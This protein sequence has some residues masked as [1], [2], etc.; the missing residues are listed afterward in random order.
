[1]EAM[2]NVELGEMFTTCSQPG[3][4][5]RRGGDS[6]LCE[7]C[8]R[9][10]GEQMC[11]DGPRPFAVQPRVELGV[12]VHHYPA[13]TALADV[14]PLLSLREKAILAGGAVAFAGAFWWGVW[15]CGRAAVLL[16]LEMS[17]GLR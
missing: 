8:T 14:F 5:R 9:W 2:G 13:R 7:G 11:G 12:M 15:T 17:G 4:R 1:M 6:D 16:C 10:I 3:C